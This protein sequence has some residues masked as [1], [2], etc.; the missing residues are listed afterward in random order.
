[1]GSVTS[2][3]IINVRRNGRLVWTG[4][5]DRCARDYRLNLDHLLDT[6]LEHGWARQG[7]LT[8]TFRSNANDLHHAASL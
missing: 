3:P 2:H 4:Y 5:A 7:E 6:M 8:F 1:M